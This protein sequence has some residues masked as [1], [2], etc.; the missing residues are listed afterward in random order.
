[1]TNWPE[2][3]KELTGQLRT[4]RSGTP[5]VMKAFSGLAQA[6]LA[7]KALDA[8]AKELIALGIAVAAYRF[9]DWMS[10]HHGN[11]ALPEFAIGVGIHSGE[12]IECLIG[13]AGS[14]T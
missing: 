4:L 13:P 6:A 10:E 8:K 7:P 5:E 1:M 2:H 12:M 9:R 11:L 14:E 3:N